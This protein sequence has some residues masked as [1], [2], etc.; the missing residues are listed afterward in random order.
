MTPETAA[1]LAFDV[2]ALSLGPLPAPEVL[3]AA[4]RRNRAAAFLHL[5]SAARRGVTTPDDATTEALLL[6]FRRDALR[7]AGIDERLVRLLIPAE[8]A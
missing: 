2:G 6:T 1:L 3:A 5:Q 8:A 4:R 7:E